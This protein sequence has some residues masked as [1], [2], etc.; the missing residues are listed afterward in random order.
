[1]IRMNPWLGISLE[2]ITMSRR[3]VWSDVGDTEAGVS[4]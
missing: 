2:G 1:M 3:Y 4:G